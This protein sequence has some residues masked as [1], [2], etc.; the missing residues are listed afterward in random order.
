MF[1]LQKQL[2]LYVCQQV[3]LPEGGSRKS[4]LWDW[5]SYFRAL[6]LLGC[7]FPSD[8]IDAPRPLNSN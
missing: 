6:S 8:R 5:P 3:M 2:S 1:Q 7:A 4:Y